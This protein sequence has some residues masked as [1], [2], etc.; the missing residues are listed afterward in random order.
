[1]RRILITLLF[2]GLLAV[3]ALA[4]Q[5]YTY[6]WDG[7]ADFLGCFDNDVEVS[8]DSSY[9]RP[10]SAGNGLC[11]TKNTFGGGYVL[12]FVAT[13]WG[14]QESDEVY[15][16][17]WRYDPMS[18]MPYFALWAHYNDALYEASDARGQD[19]AVDDGNCY[20]NAMLGMQNG[21]EEYTYTWTVKPGHS[22]MVIDA[23]IYGSTNSQMWV[24]D[25]T[26]TVPDH[27]NVRTPSTIY[28]SGGEVTP[29]DQ[30]CWTAVKQLFD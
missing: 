8:V 3:P 10:G 12:G 21:W 28:M 2:C 20:G 19:M 17:I 18:D 9:N 24:D 30:M 25:L 7:T 29:V 26:L 5:T 22:G 6:N 27:A 16:S 13:V 14:L 23:Q 15:V 4:A 11:L 1:M